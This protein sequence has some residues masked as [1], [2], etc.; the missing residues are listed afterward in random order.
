V[1]AR[2]VKLENDLSITVLYSKFSNH[3]WQANGRLPLRTDRTRMLR[4]NSHW[5]WIILKYT[6]GGLLYA[7]GCHILI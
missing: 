5:I 3:F 1:S 2:N 4:N 7:F 6:H